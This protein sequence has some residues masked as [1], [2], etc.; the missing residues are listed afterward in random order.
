MGVKEESAVTSFLAEFES[1]QSDLAVYVDRL[2]SHMSP[3]AR[4][5]VNAWEEP[6]V[7][8]D[9]IR[10]EF[11]REASHMQDLHIETVAIASAEQIVFTQRLDS[12]ILRGKPLTAHVAGVFEVDAEG[13]I[14]VWRDY[15]DSGEVAV[16]VGADGFTPAGK[17]TSTP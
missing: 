10:H 3:D 13:K 1:D 9:A 16:Q 6:F 5:H 8:H 17:R 15:F 14:A 11:L 4:F 2:L 7:G 12:L